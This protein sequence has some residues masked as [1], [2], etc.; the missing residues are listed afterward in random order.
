MTGQRNWVYWSGLTSATHLIYGASWL[1]AHTTGTDLQVVVEDFGSFQGT[2]RI[3]TDDVAWAL[4]GIEATFGLRSE[5]GLRVPAGST[6]TYLAVGS[7][8]IRP[9]L[10]LL[11]SN[12]ARR[13]SF[14]A[15]DEGFSSYGTWRTKR[16]AWVREGKP[17]ARST[18]RALLTAG[19]STL[20]R[21][22]AWRLHEQVSAGWRTN[23]HIASE[24]RLH[25]RRTAPSRTAVFCSQPWVELGL[26][27]S[28]EYTSQVLRV[29]E[30]CRAAGLNFLVRPHPV[31]DPDRYRSIGGV[32]AAER[33]AEL[34][35]AC[36]NAAVVLGAS[37]SALINLAAIHDVPVVRVSP[38][39]ISALD[40]TLSPQ[41]RSLLDTY[42]GDDVD[43]GHVE[44]AVLRTLNG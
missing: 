8:G 21:P 33:P 15:T 29:A 24:F 44:D 30:S 20:T 26:I 23:E 11:R 37:S 34:D 25:C 12:P 31:E 5:V 7:P 16:D 3:T 22:S 17:A 40:A 32:A 41:Q 38:P 35:P 2:T 42:L 13:L 14:V 27:D 36:V 19:V 6:A 1:R 10:R 18:V 9:L 4:P 43:P 28:A 39:A